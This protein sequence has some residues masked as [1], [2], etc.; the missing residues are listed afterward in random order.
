MVVTAKPG[1]V[2]TRLT[3]GR[4]ESPLTASPERVA[5]D[6]L[7]AIDRNRGV[8]YTPGFWR[9]V[10]ALV[11]SIPDPIFRRLDF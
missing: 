2:D 7:R 4:V 1:F 6:I 10:M 8:V 5:R 3:F 9:V 11:R